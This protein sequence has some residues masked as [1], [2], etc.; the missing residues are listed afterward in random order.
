MGLIFVL[1]SVS[2]A[3]LHGIKRVVRLK[4]KE[5]DSD[6][7]DMALRGS[8][9]KKRKDGL[10]IMTCQIHVKLHRMVHVRILTRAMDYGA[11]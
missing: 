5:K 10:G 7:R 4:E 9:Q 1:K 2:P 11:A 3:L 8:T 6:V